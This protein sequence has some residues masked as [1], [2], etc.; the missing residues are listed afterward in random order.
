M[1]YS[2]S[3]NRQQYR[4]LRFTNQQELVDLTELVADYI[5]P[6]EEDVLEGP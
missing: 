6:L 5:P 2:D 3:N 4:R 1:S